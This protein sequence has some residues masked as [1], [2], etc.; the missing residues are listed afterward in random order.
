MPNNPPP[1][2]RY[3]LDTN[4]LPE[5]EDLFS[6]LDEAMEEVIRLREEIERAFNQSPA[7]EM[8]HGFIIPGRADLEIQWSGGRAEVRIDLLPNHTYKE[9]LL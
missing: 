1:R 6:D 4:S 2:I 5:A 9:P 8:L 3:R 7:R